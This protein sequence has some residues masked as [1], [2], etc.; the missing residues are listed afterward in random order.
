MHIIDLSDD[1]LDQVS[2]GTAAAETV[3]YFSIRLSPQDTRADIE[4]RL[5]FCSGTIPTAQKVRTW[6]LDHL[7]TTAAKDG[8]GSYLVG[9]TQDLSSLKIEKQ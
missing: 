4:S 2:G 1:Q 6:V 3:L 9:W 5:S 8:T 7:C